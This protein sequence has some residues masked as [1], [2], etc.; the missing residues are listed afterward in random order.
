MWCQ[1]ANAPG[2]LRY[3][4][5]RYTATRPGKKSGGRFPIG[6]IASSI[7]VARPLLVKICT[8]RPLAPH[9]LRLAALDGCGPAGVHTC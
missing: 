8:A 4:L 5:V 9:P 6:Y 2:Q 7:C 1:Q 3:W